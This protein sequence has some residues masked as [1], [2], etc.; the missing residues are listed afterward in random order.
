MLI[1]ACKRG[2]YATKAGLLQW[3]T[4]YESFPFCLVSPNNKPSVYDRDPNTTVWYDAQL[5][6][7]LL[8]LGILP[9][10]RLKDIP[11]KKQMAVTGMKVSCKFSWCSDAINFKNLGSNAMG[12]L[13][14]YIPCVLHLQKRVIEKKH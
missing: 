6:R 9:A 5:K 13:E 2:G 10:S 12:S 3:D 8:Q 4:F 7:T 11:A 1:A 14:D